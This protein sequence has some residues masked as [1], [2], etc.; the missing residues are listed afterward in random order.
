MYSESATECP[1]EHR[2]SIPS[3]LI[4][5]LNHIG[6]AVLSLPLI[7]HLKT[8]F[9]QTHLTYIAG[10]K[11]ATTLLQYVPVIDELLETP[12][13]FQA[14]RNTIRHASGY[15][16][17]G[18]LILSASF[19]SAACTLGLRTGIRI[20]FNKE[21]RGI[22]LNHKFLVDT[23][24]HL[25]NRF[26]DLAIPLGIP[27]PDSPTY[28]SII[29]PKAQQIEVNQ[30]LN[31]QWGKTT[32]P[33]LIASA[34][35]RPSK[36]YLPEY[37][38]TIVQHFDPNYP[39][40]FI[41]GSMDYNTIHS[42]IPQKTIQTKNLA[43]IVPRSLLPSLIQMSRLL[44]TCDTGPMHLADAL[45]IPVIALFGATSPD[46]YGPYTQREHVLYTPPTCSPC[47]QHHCTHSISMKCMQ[48]IHPK[49]VINRVNEVLC[50]TE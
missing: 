34:T 37:W 19:V 30:I 11:G 33:I 18:T 26:L 32:P 49:T 10:T 15:P 24:T 50:L 20:G 46:H 38:Q 16:F 5:G 28:P 31:T 45:G 13:Q 36:T 47:Y 21:G 4:L 42:C 41:G 6:D 48:D 3:L 17:Y 2:R 29:L 43:G 44:I 12:F 1:T 14:L 9:P 27:S 7:H 23:S 35:T 25:V 8:H 22:F 39:I 40:G